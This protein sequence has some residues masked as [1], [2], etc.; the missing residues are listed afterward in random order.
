MVIAS[1]AENM[2][3]FMMKVGGEGV[4][5]PREEVESMDGVVEQGWICRERCSW[6][7]S[8]EDVMVRIGPYGWGVG[9]LYRE[10]DQHRARWCF[11]HPSKRWPCGHP[12]DPEL[13]ALVKPEIELRLSSVI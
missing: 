13:Q 5:D 6:E 7:W 12:S 1:R 11:L 8:A 3:H 2:L 4:I 10:D 9:P